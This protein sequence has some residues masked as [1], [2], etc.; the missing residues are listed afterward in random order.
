MEDYRNRVLSADR[1]LM[2]FNSETLVARKQIAVNKS[3]MAAETGTPAAAGTP[4]P[5]RLSA[6]VVVGFS[7]PLFETATR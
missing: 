4:K 2:A 1:T 7:F 5:E 6:W 3:P